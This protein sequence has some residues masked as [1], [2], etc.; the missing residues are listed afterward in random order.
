MGIANQKMMFLQGVGEKGTWKRWSVFDYRMSR[1]RDENSEICFAELEGD[2]SVALKRVSFQGGDQ[3]SKQA[4]GRRK[5]VLDKEN[6]QA[7]LRPP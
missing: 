6:I 3:K 2:Y 7:F 1:H 5:A 4:R